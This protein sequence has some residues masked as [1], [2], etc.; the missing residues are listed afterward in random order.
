VLGIVPDTMIL[1][2][3]ANSIPVSLA[4]VIYLADG[5]NV[6]VIEF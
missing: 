3:L 2:L 4:G 1:E 6:R 5:R